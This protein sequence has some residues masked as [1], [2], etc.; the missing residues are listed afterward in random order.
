MTQTTTTSQ[1]DHSPQSLDDDAGSSDHLDPEIEAEKVQSIER[2]PDQTPMGKEA[3]FKMFKMAIMSG[4]QSRSYL[5]N[6]KPYQAILGSF[7]KPDA[8]PASDQIYEI[9]LNSK[10]FNWIVRGPVANAGARAGA[11][12][13]VLTW[14]L[15]VGM[16]LR[17]ERQE[18]FAEAYEAQG[19]PMMESPNH[20]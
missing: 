3:F 13:P 20:G 17:Q 19:L 15:G 4:E 1:V 9:L 5:F 18:R 8:R 11:M 10:A 12:A 6:D 14:I 16:D 7:D 2:D